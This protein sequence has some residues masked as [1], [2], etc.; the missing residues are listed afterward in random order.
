MFPS[1]LTPSIDTCTYTFIQDAVST[2]SP[3]TLFSDPVTTSITLCLSISTACLVVSILSQ[4]YSQVDKI[5]SIT[6]ALYAWIPVLANPSLSSSPR[7]L[8]MALVATVWS[9]R[10][11]WNFNRRGGYRFPDVWNGEE[12]YRWP[13]LRSGKVPYLGFLREPIPWAVFN[14]TFI[15]YYQNVLLWL[16][17]APSLVVWIVESSGKCGVRGSGVR[18]SF[19]SVDAIATLLVLLLVFIEGIADNQQFAFQTEKYRI[20]KKKE[21]RTGDY[22]DGFNQ[23]GLY[24]VMRKPNYFA[25]QSIWIVFYAFSANVTA[26]EE[27][28]LNWSA[29]GFFLL[30]QLFQGSGWITERITMD[31]YRKYREVY[32]NNVGRYT[33]FLAAWRWLSDSYVSVS[34][35]E[36][37]EEGFEEKEKTKS[38]KKMNREKE[39]RPRGRSRT[40]RPGKTA[41]KAV[42]ESRSMGAQMRAHSKGMKGGSRAADSSRSKSTCKKA[43]ASKSRSK[44]TSTRNNKNSKKKI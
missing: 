7:Q 22:K 9:I 31:K 18:S 39:V 3:H 29:L 26:T 44:S 43:L 2:Y 19:D 35:E 21:K 14:V 16:T 5:W 17:A 42:S 8:A 28:W 15:A 32:C 24:S 10:L 33:P 23:K 37:E 40:E 38:M 25:E 4:N 11:T 13:L 36:G 20:I 34:E 27:S 41:S 6:P 12:D 30:V 1:S